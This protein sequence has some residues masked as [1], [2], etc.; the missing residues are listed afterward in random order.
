[1][2]QSKSHKS[3]NR[4]K[5]G[6]VLVSFLLIA[7]VAIGTTLAYLV[8]KTDDVRNTFRPSQV[9][10][11]VTEDFNGSTKS[12]VNVQNTGD[13]T[14]YIRVKL[15]TY[16]VNDEGDHIG[17]SADIPAFNPGTGWVEN[18]GYYYYTKPVAP[19]ASPD[20]PLIDSIELTGEYNDADGGKQVIE[21]MAEA[22]QSEPEEAVGTAWGVTISE[23]SVTPYI[24]N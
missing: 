22:I 24:A 15:V 9:S 13:T 7:V 5:A 19:K 8:T 14:A 16:R 17:G 12:N 10:C 23:N 21:V 20:N 4:N 1:M 18:S 6:L 2:Y 3:K 11:E